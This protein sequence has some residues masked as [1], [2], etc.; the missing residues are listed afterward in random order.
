MCGP[1]QTLG[2]SPSGLYPA[3]AAA[4]IAASRSRPDGAGAAGPQLPAVP[5][6]QSAPDARGD[7][8]AEGVC[9]AWLADR[10]PRTDQPRRLGRLTAAGKEQAEVGPAARSQLT[11]AHQQRALAQRDCSDAADWPSPWGRGDPH[12]PGGGE[13]GQAV[14][15]QAAGRELIRGPPRERRVVIRAPRHTTVC[16]SAPAIASRRTVSR[17]T[18]S[19]AA[20]CAAVRKSGSFTGWRFGLPRSRDEGRDQGPGDCFQQLGGNHGTRAGGS[21]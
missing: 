19:R 9:Q 6:G 20:S 8:I 21:V 14:R 10:T 15:V 7:A 16:G 12:P 5:L 18:P 13:P 3:A 1:G 17:E 4:A 2:R 11:P